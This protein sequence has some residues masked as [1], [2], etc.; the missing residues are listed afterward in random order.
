MELAKD[1]RT[2][3]DRAPGGAPPARAA[4]LGPWLLM[5][6]LVITAFNLRPAISGL[7]PLLEEVRDDLGMNGVVAGLLTSVPPLCFALFGTT[8]PRLARRLGPAVVA[9]AGLGAI[10]AGLVLRSL[11]GGTVFFLAASALALAGIAVN[12]VLMPVLVK[13]YFPDRV[14]TATGFYSTAFAL[15]TSSAAA[16]TVPLTHAAGESWRVSLALWAVVALPGIPAWLLAERHRRAAAPA[17][18]AASAGTAPAAATGR[19]RLLRSRTAWALACFFGLQSTAAYVTM[20]WV[21]QMFR[22]AGVSA[23]TAGVLL[24]IIMG[25]GAP[26]GFVIPRLAT[27]YRRQG[28]LIAVLGVSGLLAYAGLWL[29]PAGGAW[30][31]A[32][33]LGIANC[34]FP[35]ALTMIGLRS[36]TSAGVA[37][38][39]AFVQSF[40][41]LISVPGPL[42]VGTLNDVTGGWEVPLALLA[43]LMAAQIAVGFAAGRD[44]CVD[45]GH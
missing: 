32:V 31:W 44:R 35:V 23:G 39:S 20:G 19:P 33:L 5:A 29:A 11:A 30:L 2:L 37:R 8:A 3:H 15:G 40:G 24:A 45:D 16:L 34:A 27:R 9:A 28:P 22:D 42:L 12:N 38:L 17:S 36:R 41:Y 43:V 6:G 10:A 4:R 13:R 21:P 1:D 25:I 7:S 14:G 18:A 26:L